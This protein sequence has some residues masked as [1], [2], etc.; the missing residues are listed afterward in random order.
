MSEVATWNAPET[1]MTRPNTSGLTRLVDWAQ[2]AD[3]AYQLAN[4]L[5]STA[6]CPEQFRGKPADA[7][8]AMLAGG[9]LGLSPLTALGAFDV[10]QGRAAARAITLRA[11]VQSKGHE[12]V[13]MESNAS[14]CKMRGRRA[15]SS[16][17]QTVNWT[18]DRARD[19][20]LT[21]KSNWKSQPQA[22]L[23]A[24]ATSEL[25]RLVASDAILGIAGGYS[26]EEVADGGSYDAEVTEVTTTPAARSGTRKMS[27][28]PK[29]ANEDGTPAPDEEGQ[30]NAM[31]ATFGDATKVGLMGDEREVRLDYI[32][33]VIGREVE[34]SNDLTWDEVSQVIDAL[35]A[36][37]EA[38]EQP[39]PEQPV[40]A[41][42]VED[43]ATS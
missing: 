13:M 1:E 2:E 19:L 16:E 36:D 31:F 11:L 12:I 35:K 30:R 39:F 17:W 42:I 8:A 23:V 37:I 15:G 18:I 26:S 3:A 6:F 34:S 9:E 24:R 20:N 25:C 32:G 40:D 22:M 5:T 14:R 43:G 28:K 21:N 27:R 4:R 10:I 41:E 33:Q 7:A 38:F 29:P